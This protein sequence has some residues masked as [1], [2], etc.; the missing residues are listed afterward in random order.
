MKITNLREKKLIILPFKA[1][2][3]AEK[4]NNFDF[5]REIIYTI[6]NDHF[7]KNEDG[8]FISTSERHIIGISKLVIEI[9]VDGDSMKILSV[10]VNFNRE[11]LLLNENSYSI[12]CDSINGLNKR[13]KSFMEELYK[14]DFEKEIINK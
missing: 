8:L 7:K 14:D 11:N 2:E 1:K 4:I 10:H 9:K 12:I 13:I 3:I 6:L 5:E